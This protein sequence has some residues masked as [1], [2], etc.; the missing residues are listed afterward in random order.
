MV[1]LLA[2]AHERGCESELADALASTLDAG[3]LPDMVRLGRM[4]APGIAKLPE[5]VVTLAPLQSYEALLGA[6]MTGDAA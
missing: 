5:V 2:L 1:D 3:D 4:F 6:G